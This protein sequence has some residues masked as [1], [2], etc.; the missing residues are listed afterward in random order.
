M[1]T[2]RV[3]VVAAALL[4]AACSSGGDDASPEDSAPEVTEPA[5][6]APSTDAAEPED[7]PESTEPAD[8][9]PTVVTEPADDVEGD[10]VEG[11]DV[12][13]DDVEG[14]DSPTTDGDDA[15]EPLVINGPAEVRPSCAS[16]ARGVTEFTL[17]A[18]GGV[19]DVRIYVPETASSDP[20]PAVL[21]WHGLGSNGPEQAAFSGYETLAETEGFIV[22]HA[23]GLDL[24]GDGQTSWELVQFDTAERDDLA[25][26]DALIDLVVADWCVDSSRIYSTGMSNGGLF[27]SEL[28]CNRSNRIAAAASIAGTTHAPTCAPERAVPYISFH[29]TAD[30]VVPFDDEDPSVLLPAPAVDALMDDS[31]PGEFAEFAADAGCELDPTRVEETAEV[32]RY[33]YAGCADEVPMAFYEI[34]GGG[35]TWPSSPLSDALVDFGFFTQDI[36]AT[37]DAWAFMSQFSL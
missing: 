21:N 4:I 19:H 1:R 3:L 28:V 13:G 6:T 7:A 2:N 10:D 34:V 27:T 36:D 24:A 33:D 5:A 26:A 18:G 12:E 11:D 20:A 35:H 31:T 29:G 23:T 14:D 25:F 37:A 17:D 15:D 16:L 8:A 30:D 32:I 22:V 9:E